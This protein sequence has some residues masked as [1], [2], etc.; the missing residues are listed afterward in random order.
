[1]SAHAPNIAINGIASWRRVRA[2]QRFDTTRREV[3]HDTGNDAQVRIFDADLDRARGL[4]FSRRYAPWRLSRRHF[5]GRPF[6]GSEGQ[7]R[8]AA[9]R[10]RSV[11][12]AA[13]YDVY[14]I[15]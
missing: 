11:D 4:I 9:R 12:G 8:R 2:K 7:G 1:V 13:A 6:R 10:L 15:L 14:E 5:Q 3:G